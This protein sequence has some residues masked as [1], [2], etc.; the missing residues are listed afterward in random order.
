LI[1]LHFCLQGS[2]L[3]QLYLDD[4]ERVLFTSHG[5][6]SCRV[7]APSFSFFILSS[8]V[9][10]RSASRWS[11]IGCLPIVVGGAVVCL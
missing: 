4:V 11:A 10:R 3:L 7:I 1:A 8:P 6:F 5:R 2:L 9:G